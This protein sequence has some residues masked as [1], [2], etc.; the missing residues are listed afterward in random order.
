MINYRQ[1]KERY[2]VNSLGIAYETDPIPL[3]HSSNGT[4][5]NY[6]KVHELLLKR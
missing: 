3:N 1:G 4:K 6:E 5:E 2:K